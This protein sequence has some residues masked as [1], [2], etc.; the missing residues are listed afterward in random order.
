MKFYN[1]GMSILFALSIST[2]TFAEDTQT[3]VADHSNAVQAASSEVAHTKLS[4]NEASV[5]ELLKIKGMKPNNA[6]ALV[7]YRKKHGEFK[8][9]E[10]IA[11]V[12]GF[13]RMKMQTLKQIEDQLRV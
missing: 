13:K 5:R 2:A 7:K 10:E 9:V 8:S 6:K 3:P 11:S 1:F 12:K 4:L